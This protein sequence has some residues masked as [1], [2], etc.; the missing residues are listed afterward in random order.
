MWNIKSKMRD[1]YS[2]LRRKLKVVGLVVFSRS[3]FLASIY[4]LFLSEEFRREHRA[5]L[6]GRLNYERSCA[7]SRNSNALLRRN[8]HR[9]EKGLVMRPQKLVFA[10]E[11][12]QDT[13]NCFLKCKQ[14]DMIDSDEAKWAEDVLILYFSEERGSRIIEEAKS[15]FLKIQKIELNELKSI[16]YPRSAS[17]Q[18]SICYDDFRDLCLQ[19]RSVRWYLPKV[20]PQEL[21]EKAIAIAAMAPSACN[22]QPFSFGVFNKKEDVLAIANCAMGTKGFAENIQSIIVVIGDLSCYPFER[23]RHLIYIDSSLAAMQLMLALE[24]LGLS[25]CPLNWPDIDERERALAGLLG[26]EYSERPVMLI[27]VGFADPN[28]GI[29]YSQKKPPS[30]LLRKFSL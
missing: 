5:T 13:V 11:Y 26:L 6:V 3:D 27:S 23:D 2:L 20:V 1:V 8:V 12:I 19:R 4:Y 25:S 21:I 15:D 22:R 24:T 18:S 10:E 7:K 9:L 16:P 14:F 30:L 28:G 29:P 17:S